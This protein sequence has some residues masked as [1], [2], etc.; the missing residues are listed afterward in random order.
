MQS[1]SRQPRLAVRIRKDR[2]N[3]CDFFK[4]AQQNNN[5]PR[6]R[7]SNHHKPPL[8]T[9]TFKPAIFKNS[10]NQF[11]NFISSNKIVPKKPVIHTTTTTTT[12]TTTTSFKNPFLKTPVPIYLKSTT[13]L[14]RPKRNK[15][16]PGAPPT[17]SGTFAPTTPRPPLPR[18]PSPSPAAFA[19]TSPRPPP[20]ILSPSPKTGAQS[21]QKDKEFS[22]L[23]QAW[24][25]YLS[26]AK[27]YSK[28]YRV[29][30]DIR[31]FKQ[32]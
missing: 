30:V 22:E 11:K 27:T 2:S 17:L 21:S 3:I 32:V 18:T 24:L 26:K 9:T 16:R 6:T 14:Y 12:A 4:D 31:Q 8:Q 7:T 1:K 5:H 19:H 20:R 25:N 29:R 23:R 15:L 10:Q 28:K 13:P